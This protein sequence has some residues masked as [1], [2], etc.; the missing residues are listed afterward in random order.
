MR[1]AVQ[2]LSL[3][4]LYVVHPGDQSYPMDEGIEALAI[5]DLIQ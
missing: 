2:D 5:A 4:T 3:S 1:V